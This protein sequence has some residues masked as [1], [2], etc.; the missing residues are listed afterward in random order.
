[1][2]DSTAT[3][4]L[5]TVRDFIRYGMSRFTAAGLS[6]GHGTDN[7][8]DE[9]AWL[10]L[11]ALHMPH[12]M[13]GPWLECRLT[14]DE[15]ARVT[16]LLEQRV[17]TRKPAAY[18]TGQAWFMGLEFFVDERVLVPRSPLAELIQQG[19]APWIEAGAV[20]RVLDLCTGSGCIGIA[21]AHVFDE[22]K[23][24]L[25][26]ISPDALVVARENIRRHG[27][28]GRVEA[29]QSD[30]F[31]GLGGR[32]YDIIVSNPPYVDARDMAALTPEFRHEPVLG[33]AS[34]PDGLDAALEILRGAADHLNPGG[35]LV[36]EV[37]NSAPALEARLPDVPFTWLEFES[38]GEGVFLLTAEQLQAL[39]L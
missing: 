21:C 15:R 13:T 32:R 30:L 24:D 27:L 39:D 38:G 9:A 23:V 34:G 36:V 3:D 33:L 5:L 8:L 14:R 11:H 31:K 4:G 37:G 25:G 35:I 19:F 12:D 20:H 10:V 18:L 6:F 29:V 7:A 28:E 2:T 1:M 16:E 26:D 22:A 17:Q